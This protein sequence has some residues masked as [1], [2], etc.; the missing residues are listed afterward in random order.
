MM[1]RRLARL[2]T[3]AS[4]TAALALSGCGGGTAPTS[5]G[6]DPTPAPQNTQ[7]PAPSAPAAPKQ[8]AVL[9]IGLN[10]D[11]PKLD[12]HQ[13]TALVDRQVFASLFDRLVEVDPNLNIT[14]GLAE[15]WKISDDG[16]TYTFYLRKGVKFHDGT[17]FD[18]EA[19]KYNFERMF[20]PEL[21][22]P[23]AGEISAFEKATV[24][25][26]HTIQVD[27]KTAFGGFL[28]ALS[29]RAG[30]MVS[31]TA[32][33]ATGLDFANEPI[34]TGP[35]KFKDRIKGDSITLVRNENYWQEGLPKAAGIIYKTVTDEN[36]K[37][38]NLQSGQLHAI[39]T[40]PAKQV[41]QL[42][43]DNRVQL[44]IGPSLQY[45]GV[46]VN[47]AVAPLNDKLV[48]QAIDV[49]I[50]R[51]ALV[52][53]VFGEVAIPANSPF[54]PGTPANDG[55][56]IAK[57]DVAKAKQLLAEAGHPNGFA[58]SLKIQPSPVNQQIAQ[59]LQNMLGEV[60]INVTIEQE[61]FGQ[62]LD[63]LGKGDFQMGQVGWSGR[64]DPDGNIYNFV[65]TG[66]SNN[67]SN[68]SNPTVDELLQQARIPSDMNQR[69]EMY[70]EIMS[71]VWDEVPYIY[72]WHP[73]D[74]KGLGP[75][76]RGF[77]PYPDG[78]IRTVNLYME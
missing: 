66:A 14:P 1:K 30:M 49:A 24:I 50:D 73:Q 63:K 53:V 33:K 60:G 67:Y 69:K 32:A 75:T 57:P 52:N 25:D 4:V 11:P 70:S 20:E 58:T 37:L 55:T 65:R 22:S 43:T 12:P 76:V 42:K 5:P 47:T 68:Y 18:A 41:P 6:S 74:V 23:R 61:E 27:L 62:L 36:V 44:S 71:I 21:N 72:L 46:W 9:S 8:D 26:S 7:A 59:V 54:A 38:V 56:P 48:R 29:D 40:V 39:D 19:A 34:G 35:F 3:A 16:L 10:A 17:D 2:L 51:D 78:L 31:P 13:S 28:Y 15:D 77:T 45:Q 64:P